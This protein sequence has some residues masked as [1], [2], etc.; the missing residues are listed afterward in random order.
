MK[1]LRFTGRRIETSKFLIPMFDFAH[2]PPMLLAKL[3]L[4]LVYLFS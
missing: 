4:Y 3:H 1:N 2:T